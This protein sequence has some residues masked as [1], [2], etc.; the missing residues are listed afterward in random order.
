ML[1]CCIC[2]VIPRQQMGKA[3]KSFHEK[4]RMMQSLVWN[5]TDFC[6]FRSRGY[7]TQSFVADAT[8]G[9]LIQSHLEIHI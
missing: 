8:F 1:L 4:G 6:R 7:F 9:I 5:Q 2:Y 3:N